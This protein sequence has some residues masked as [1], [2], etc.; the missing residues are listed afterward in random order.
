MAL[1]KKI[2]FTNGVN[3]SYHY[4]SD[5]QTN[6]KD[7]IVKLKIDSYTDETYRQKEKENKLNKDR[8]EELLELIFKENEKK[9]DARNVDQVK[10]WSEEANSL[11]NQFVN[12]LDLKVIST[13]I[14]LK[15]VT[16]LNIN[17]LYNLLK[18]IDIYQNAKDI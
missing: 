18:E 13:N 4:I 10:L 17:N 15:D 1:Y 6:G 2:K 16:D 7:K 5:I 12:D 14:E 8:Y 3:I 9:E 11:V